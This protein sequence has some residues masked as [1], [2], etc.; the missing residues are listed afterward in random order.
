MSKIGIGI[1]TRNRKE[2]FRRTLEHI[3]KFSEK[4]AKIIVVE[5]SDEKKRLGVARAKNKCL[6]LLRECD[7]IFL[8]DDDL[9]P[10]K[11]GWEK[12][13]IEAAEKTGF[14]HFCLTYEDQ[15]FFNVTD[16][17][18]CN[19]VKLKY[20]AQPQGFMMY[21]GKECLEKVGGFD[22]SFG[23]YGGEHANYSWR[24]KNLGVSPR[25]ATD[26][27][28]S[29]E[30]FYSMDLSEKI[31]SSISQEERKISEKQRKSVKE[32]SSQKLPFAFERIVI[33]GSGILA[34]E[35]E[36]VTGWPTLSRKDG[37]NFQKIESYKDLIEPYDTIVNCIACTDTYSTE[38]EKH[39]ETNYRGVVDLVDHCNLK[40]KKLVHFSSDYVYENSVS[41]VSE[42]EIP[43]HGNTWYA[44]TKLLGDSYIELRSR[45]Y[46][47]LRGSHK[48]TPFAYPRAWND[49]R[50]NFDYIDVMTNLYVSLIQKGYKG[51][52]NVGTDTKTV[53]EMAL[54][55]NSD[56][57]PID[58]PP[59]AP[60]DVTMNLEKMRKALNKQEGSL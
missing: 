33:L 43:I 6:Y 5:D 54:Q 39:W 36:K 41:E 12:F 59:Q 51:L 37:L 25:H 40:E 18:E 60:K 7:H 19:G 28:G 58:S 46:L 3:E 56:V 10:I 8:F 38:R 48:P 20:H 49:V 26:I 50:G 16:R 23:I 34:Q 44:Y 52:Y 42:S 1:T 17:E 9:Y 13:Y 45:N 32:F 30:Y 31:E 47:I 35:I 24:A 11:Q 29:N 53:Y 22:T 4:D 2:I 57:M 15:I 55:T 27:E 21:I 14:S